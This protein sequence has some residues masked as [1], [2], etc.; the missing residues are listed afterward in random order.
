MRGF[1]ET[2]IPQVAMNLKLD[3]M[4][5]HGKGLAVRGAGENVKLDKCIATSEITHALNNPRFAFN[6][7]VTRPKKEL[8]DCPRYHHRHPYHHQDVF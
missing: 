5:V 3:S 2:Y 6:C 1:H 4:S 7:S 8:V